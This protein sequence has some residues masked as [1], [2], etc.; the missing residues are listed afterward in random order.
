MNRNVEW[1]EEHPYMTTTIDY[2]WSD[3]RMR[4]SPTEKHR[5]KWQKHLPRDASPRL[6]LLAIMGMI[7]NCSQW[8]LNSHHF[9]QL[10]SLHGARHENHDA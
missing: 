8:P 10:N 6:L 1:L 2:G 5:L 7:R 4:L 3:H 9:I